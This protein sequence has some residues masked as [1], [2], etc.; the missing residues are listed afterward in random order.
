MREG[1][2]S[3]AWRDGSVWS[4]APPHPPATLSRHSADV[5]VIG[6][7]VTGMLA[8]TMLAHDGADVL[9][10]DRHAVGGV[11]TRNSTAK[12]SALQGTK[13]SEVAARRSPEVATA[14]GAAQLDAVAGLRALIAGLG[15]DCRFTDAPA[16]TYAT[17]PASAE[18]AFREYEAARDA[19]LSVQ[20][21]TETELPFPVLGAVRLGDQAH[22]DPLAFCRGL[23]TALGTGHVAEHTAVREVV[24]DADGCRVSI[25][26]DVRLACDHVVVATQGP[27]SDPA[28]LANRC[29]PMQSY[30]I[31]ARLPGDVPEGLYLSCDTRVRSLRP[32]L[33]PGGVDAVVGGEG[34][35]IGE[36]EATPRRWDALA[37]WTRDHFGSAEVTHRWATHDLVPTDHVPFVGRLAPRSKR[38]WVATGF[39]KWGMTNGYVAANVISEAIGGRD[40]S[41][42]ST[43]D[44]CRIA[45]SVN[46]DLISIGKSAVTHLLVDRVRHPALPRCTHQGCVLRYDDA[47]NTWDCPCHGSRFSADGA[48]VQGPAVSPLAEGPPAP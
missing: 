41:W 3:I 40:V 24:E 45:P 20:W 38:R 37:E 25:D 28:L 27:I 10:V 5:V 29:T 19:G 43:F 9:V 36:G 47:L 35:P 22:F 23:A 26:R 21:V 42:A 18:V 44:S 13:Y 34:H 31:A 7:G 39:A 4:G 8:A 2:G 46:R 48:V 12:I 16:F 30:A 11:A 14:Y 32:V 33:T 6:A 1:E 17:E 15:I